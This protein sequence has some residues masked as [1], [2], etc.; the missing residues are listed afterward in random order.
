MLKGKADYI[1][2]FGSESAWNGP[3][4]SYRSGAGGEYVFFKIQSGLGRRRH[5][6]CICG[7]FR[8]SRYQ[9]SGLKS[10]LG[11][12]SRAPQKTYFEFLDQLAVM[13]PFL[14]TYV[15]VQ[16]YVRSAA[17]SMFVKLVVGECADV[18]SF[19][20]PDSCEATLSGAGAR[21][22]VDGSGTIFLCQYFVRCMFIYSGVHDLGAACGTEGRTGG[23][24]VGW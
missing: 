12:L 21:H 23:P 17:P 9:R 19:S 4:L 18:P 24:D 5:V 3:I 2:A 13:I 11:C 15:R 20:P 8:F 14:C 10:L 7:E 16:Y 22:S 1:L 6:T